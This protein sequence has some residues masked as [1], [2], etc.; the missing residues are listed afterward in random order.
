M[1]SYQSLPKE[2][3]VYFFKNN[4]GKIIYIGKGNSLRDRVSSYFQDPK[5]L[6]PKTAQMI[7]DAKSLNY[8]VVVS[9]IDA[10]LLEA[11]LIR[12]FSPKYNVE[13][14]D[15]KAYPL[16]EITIKEPVPQVHFARKENNPKARYFG[17][18]PTGSNLTGL[19]RFLRKIFPYVSQNHPGNKSCLRS[20]MG[21]CPCPAVFTDHRAQKNYQ[22]TVHLLISFLEGHHVSLERNLEKEMHQAAVKQDFEKAS[23][24]KN[25]LQ[26]LQYITAPRTS[27]WEYEVNPNLAADKHQEEISRLAQI[28][29]LPIM[30]KIECYDIA[31][32]SGKHTAAAEVVFVA[33]LPD[34]SLY[35]RYRIK[36]NAT[37]DDFACMQEVINRRL[38]S[39]IPLPDLMVIDGGKGQLNA[40]IKAFQNSSSIINSKNKSITLNNNPSSTIRPKIIA[41]AKRL[42][43]IYT[44]TGEEIQ[45]SLSSPELQLLQRL[46][47]EAHRFSRKYHILLRR[48]SMLS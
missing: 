14:K 15:G 46:R 25:K 18:Y 48:K 37:P 2:P 19:L 5:K 26:Q 24:L 17:P 10:L 41:L 27:P 35:R 34:K 38:K 20:H 32:I 33:G 39:D 28:L 47:D 3:G 21:L 30:Q 13:W 8:M 6:L 7:A 31:N 22:H 4:K 43:T 11:N 42:E 40:A 9:E 44:D 45:L 16:I 12:K 1:L 36:F 29:K 23:D